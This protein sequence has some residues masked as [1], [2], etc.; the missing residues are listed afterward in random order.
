M[1][2]FTVQGYQTCNLAEIVYKGEEEWKWWLKLEQETGWQC[3]MGDLTHRVHHWKTAKHMHRHR[4]YT[5]RNTWI[6]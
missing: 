4:V 6:P 1:D 2:I 3:L 5:V